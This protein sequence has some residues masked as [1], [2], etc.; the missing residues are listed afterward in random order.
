MSKKK[1]SHGA[2]KH[3]SAASAAKKSAPCSQRV[4]KPGQ[5]TRDAESVSRASPAPVA[6]TQG[7]ERMTSAE[8][9]ANMIKA[10]FSAWMAGIL[11]LTAG[12]AIMV[13]VGVAT[14]FGASEKPVEAMLPIS[15]V[16]EQPEPEKTFTV[17]EIMQAAEQSVVSTEFMQKFFD[18]RIVYKEGDELKYVPI[19]RTLPMNGY[20][21]SRLTLE[22]GRWA[23]EHEGKKAAFGIDVSEYQYEIDW[24]KVA[25]DGVEFAILRLGYRGY[26]ESGVLKLDQYFESN[27]KGATEAGIEVGVYLFSQAVS[28]AEAVEEAEFMIENISGYEVT[29]PLIL[30][31][32]DVPEDARTVGMTKEETT[33]AVAAF[34][35]AVEASGYRPMIYANTRWFVAKVDM[36]R[37][38]KYDKWLAQ[39]YDLPF[40]PYEFQM[41]QYTDQ[42]SID[43][44]EGTVDMNLCFFE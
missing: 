27:I 9:P 29:Y 28:A 14:G 12:V 41:W 1:S 19:D 10:P 13:A 2:K 38:V 40:F 42:G 4:K 34:C 33:D 3:P 26:G 39:Y 31:I 15:S 6:K 32:E 37:L 7:A 43:G 8:Q 21:W 25:A 20:D 35:E 44:I 24:E 17:D 11:G 30:D 18:D 23:Y 5:T 16:A 36:S 22:D